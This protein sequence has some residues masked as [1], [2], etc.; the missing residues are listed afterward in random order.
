[1]GGMTRD[2]PFRLIGGLHRHV[3]RL[4]G[5]EIGARIVNLPVLLL[6]TTGRKS[7]R[8]RTKHSNFSRLRHIHVGR[9]LLVAFEEHQLL[10]G[11]AGCSQE[12]HL[13]ERAVLVDS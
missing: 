6:T 12:D 3:Y 13:G 9:R 10:W 7:G 2:L 8:P 5:G 4:T 11:G 1:M